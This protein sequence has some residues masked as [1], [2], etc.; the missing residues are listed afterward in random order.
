MT[1]DNIIRK[2]LI[3][4]RSTNWTYKD[5]RRDASSEIDNLCTDYLGLTEDLDCELLCDDI[6]KMI[7]DKDWIDKYI[8]WQ[9][10]ISKSPIE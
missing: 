6:E 8:G 4:I 1:A 7:I 3:I 9:T 2:I 10:D 5:C